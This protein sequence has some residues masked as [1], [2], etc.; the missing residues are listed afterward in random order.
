MEYHLYIYA[1]YILIKGISSIYKLCLYYTI[2]LIYGISPV[3]AIYIFKYG[4]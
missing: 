2:I 4:I 1:I 3:Q